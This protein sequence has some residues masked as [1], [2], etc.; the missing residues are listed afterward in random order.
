MGKSEVL[1][2]VLLVALGASIYGMLATVVKLAYN[3]GYTTAEVTTS[4]FTIGL[5]GLVLLNLIQSK[6]TKKKLAKPT[7]KD[8][9][10]LL[11]AGTSYGLTSLFYYLSVQFI[12]VSIAIV[13]LMQSVWI[14]V[15]V[16]SI[17][18]KELPSAR[19]VI[20]AVIILLGTLLATNAIHSEVNLDWRGILFGMLAAMSFATTMFAS[21]RIANHLPALKKSLIMLCGGAVM[22][23]SFL[24]LTQVGP[25]YFSSAFQGISFPFVE[26]RAFDFSIFWKYGLFLAIFGTILPPILLNLG[27]PKTGLGLGSIVSSVELPVSVLMAFV[28]LNEQVLSIQWMGIVLI[29]SAIAYMNWNSIRPIKD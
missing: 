6:T 7:K 27:F 10:Q 19:K 28:L 14:G 9:W 4:Q 1:K 26:V 18:N 15:V 17:M 5:L 29:L 20:S 24:I 8:I 23:F 16:E 21:N 12:N 2:G 25:F 22:V 11:L 3:A 13:L